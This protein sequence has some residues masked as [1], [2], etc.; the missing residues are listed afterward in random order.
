[1]VDKTKNIQW[2]TLNFVLTSSKL[3]LDSSP[4][5]C[6]LGYI[7]V[8]LNIPWCKHLIDL[9]ACPPHLIDI[10]IWKCIFEVGVETYEIGRQASLG[11]FKGDAACGSVN[12]AMWSLFI[13]FFCDIFFG[14]FGCTPFGFVDVWLLDT[15]Y[16]QTWKFSMMSDLWESA[17]FSW[18]LGC[19]HNAAPTSLKISPTSSISKTP[20]QGL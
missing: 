9:R 15:N 1:M 13:C 17:A 6:R 16:K 5:H 7:K 14:C 3:S 12:I 18:L 11:C 20:E 8:S 2:E 19:S 10:V 4:G